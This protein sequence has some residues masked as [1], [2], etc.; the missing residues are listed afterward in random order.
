MSPLIATGAVNHVGLTVSD[1]DRAREF[2]TDV[3][4]F[5][6]VAEFGPKLL[7][8]NGGVLLALAPAPHQPLPNDRFDENRI[9]LDHLS[10][11]VASR[12]DLDQAAQALDA[13]GVPRGEILDLAPFRMYVLAF[14]D[15]DNIQL[16]LTA[17]YES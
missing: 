10:L 11:A 6:Q 15:P 9:G 4:G 13:R 3:L 14:R 8:H 12:A 17:P 16:E 5:Q 1:L 7:F 2:Y